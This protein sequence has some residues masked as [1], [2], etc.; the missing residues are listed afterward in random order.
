MKLIIP[1]VA[2][3][4]LVPNSIKNFGRPLSTT[5]V[6][7]DSNCASNCESLPAMLSRYFSFRSEERRVGKECR[8]RWSPYH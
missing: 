4:T 6:E 1:S 7:R 8:S 3:S 5:D 2:D